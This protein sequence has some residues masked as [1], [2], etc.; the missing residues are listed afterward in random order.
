M[1]SF[2]LYK[3]TTRQG[4]QYTETHLPDITL[5]L[6]ALLL[7]QLSNIDVL[8]QVDRGQA[9]R[10]QANTSDQH[11]AHDMLVSANNRI[12]L[13]CAIQERDL[14]RNISED[15]RRVHL[16][17]F[18]QTFVELRRQDVIPHG[19]GNGETNRRAEAAEKT[20]ERD[21]GGNFLV[22]DGYHDGKLSADGEDTSTNTD[23]DLCEG[24][25]TGVGVGCA[26]GEEKRCAE[27]NNRYT[28]I[29]SP[30]EV[31]G[32]ADDERDDRAK[33]GRC[34]GERVEDVSGVRDALP[35]NDEQ[36]RLE[37]GVPD[38]DGDEHDAVESA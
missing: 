36:V 33:G 21:N 10:H 19:A 22:R 28:G 3:T 6:L 2:A 26:E 5:G 35:V 1:A 30:L 25:D 17:S 31:S 16:A 14:R 9:E 15:K 37:V 8:P 18:R 20:P 11:Q 13:R 12:A 29:S 24:D 4:L 27:N 23:D 7:L 32:I 34:E 38:E